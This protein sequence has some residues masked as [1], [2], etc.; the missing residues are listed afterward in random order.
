MASKVFGSITYDTGAGTGLGSFTDGTTNA[1]TIV[2]EAASN[3]LD[4]GPIVRGAFQVV[5]GASEAF[6]FTVEGSIDG[7]NFS[8][9]AYG[10]GSSG[11]YTQAAATVAADAKGIFFLPDADVLRYIRLN[12]SA[13]NAANGT[14]VTFFGRRS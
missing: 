6:T 11:A 3:S 9:I 7:T 13:S 12:I 2:T 5:N 14:V 4:I 10:T 1:T 8:T